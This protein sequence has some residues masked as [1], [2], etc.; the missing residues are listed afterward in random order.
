MMIGRG[1]VLAAGRVIAAH[2][3]SVLPIND[4]LVD[5]ILSFGLPLETLLAS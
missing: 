3:D 4:I 2:D 1:A 5:A